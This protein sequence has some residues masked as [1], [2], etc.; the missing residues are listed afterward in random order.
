MRSTDASEVTEQA[1]VVTS[2]RVSW[3]TSVPSILQ[4]QVNAAMLTR[5]VFGASSFGGSS[6]GAEVGVAREA[7]AC[8]GGDVGGD[9]G[10][11]GIVSNKILPSTQSIDRL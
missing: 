5:V 7:E 4:M 10:A 8:R 2:E 3:K 1:F 6:R 11:C 9:F